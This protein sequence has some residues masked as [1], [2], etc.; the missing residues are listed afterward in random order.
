MV[1]IAN[2][3]NFLYV[4][5]EKSPTGW[6]EWDHGYERVRPLG[7]RYLSG[8]VVGVMIHERRHLDLVKS[9]L[10]VRVAGETAER[11]IEVGLGSRFGVTLLTG[12]AGLT[13]DDLERPI[14][15]GVQ[16]VEGAAE[17]RVYAAPID[18]SGYGPTPTHAVEAIQRRLMERRV[19]SG[20]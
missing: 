19:A 7:S 8:T 14:T 15:I 17:A 11:V 4:S 20:F 9:M 16:F 12:L 13:T 6:Y 1:T 10:R 5:F 2:A 18:L 3:T